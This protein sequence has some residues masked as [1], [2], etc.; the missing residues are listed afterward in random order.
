MAT[1]RHGAVSR[2]MWGCLS[3]DL[4]GD[5]WWRSGS[6]RL[7]ETA[8]E[9][10]DV[11]QSIDSVHEANPAGEPSQRSRNGLARREL[12]LVDRGL[13]RGCGQAVDQD[14]RAL[15]ETVERLLRGSS[16]LLGGHEHGNPVAHRAEG[17]AR[18]RA[19]PGMPPSCIYTA[20]TAPT[21]APTVRPNA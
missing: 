7:P 6:S 15:C 1:L 11:E 5:R 9:I 17:H 20:K 18:E 13:N 14:F 4:S 19:T 12:S 16:G 3:G 10:L 2:L 8:D 21:A